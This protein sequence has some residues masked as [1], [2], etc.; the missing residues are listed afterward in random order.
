MLLFPLILGFL[1]MPTEMALVIVS[2]SICLAFINIDKIAEFRGAG[3]YAKMK[4]ATE[5]VYASI[6]QIQELSVNISKAT[7]YLTASY[8]RFG[9]APILNRIV[10]RDSLLKSLKELGV[11]KESLDETQK[12][13]NSFILFDHAL[14]I[15]GA[16]KTSWPTADDVDG[17]FKLRADYNISPETFREIINDN[18]LVSD[19]I[20]E[21]FEDYKY[22]YE[23]KKI[24]R[25]DIWKSN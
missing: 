10:V 19:E 12:E 3:F 14:N 1:G 21:A 2:G 16:T 8:G 24:R 6:E 23:C 4:E 13:F 11:K 7:M 22:F 15:K 5:R 9:G 17:L 18:N 25:P 20:D